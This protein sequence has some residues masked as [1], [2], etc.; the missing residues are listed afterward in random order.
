MAERAPL[1]V[2]NAF[3]NAG[4]L[5]VVEKLAY[6]RARA[7]AEAV[8]AVELFH[9]DE[10]EALRA[11]YPVLR[12]TDVALIPLREVGIELDRKVQRLARRRLRLRMASA[13]DFAAVEVV[14][15]EL[16]ER[17]AELASRVVAAE[18]KGRRRFL[19]RPRRSAG[20]VF[21][22]LHIPDDEEIV[23]WR[24]DVIENPDCNDDDEAVAKKAMRRRGSTLLDAYLEAEVEVAMELRR[25]RR[26]HPIC[27]RD[28]NPSVELDDY[29]SALRSAYV[30][31]AAFMGKEEPTLVQVEE[32]IRTRSVALI[33]DDRCVANALNEYCAAEAELRLAKAHRQQTKLISQLRFTTD[34]AQYKHRLWSR[35]QAR[36]RTLATIFDLPDEEGDF[37]D[38]D[39]A[40]SLTDEGTYVAHARTA[41]AK[42]VKDSYFLFLQRQKTVFTAAGHSSGA[43][44]VSE[45]LKRRL[46]QLTADA[47]RLQRSAQRRSNA[48]L[49]RFPFL[50]TR[51]YMSVLLPELRLDEDDVFVRLAEERE[52]LLKPP[53]ELRDRYPFLPASIDGVPIEELGLETDAE[54]MRLASQREDLLGPLRAKLKGVQDREEAMRTRMSEL[55]AAHIAEENTQRNKYSFVDIQEL[56]V[57]LQRL[58]LEHDVPFMSMYAEYVKV[59]CSQATEGSS[60]L[61]GPKAG[62]RNRLS[63]LL[64]SFEPTSA[65]PVLRPHAKSAAHKK[66]E[67][68]MRDWV[69][70][71]AEEEAVWE[72]ATMME[73]ESLADRFPFLPVEPIFG[74]HLGETG[75]LQDVVFC[76]IAAEVER[77]RKNI[78]PAEEIAA[79]EKA[80]VT[81]VMKL[82]EEKHDESARRRRCFPHLPQ[83]VA[84]VLVSDMELPESIGIYE[85]DAESA[86]LAYHKAAARAKRRRVWGVEEDEAVR[87]RHPFLEMNDMHGVPLRQLSL[88][89]DSIF[90]SYLSKWRKVLS[91]ETIDREKLRIY[92]DLLRE[93]AEERALH[94]VDV[95]TFMVGRLRALQLGDALPLEMPLLDMHS[96]LVRDRDPIVAEHESGSVPAT[97][98]EDSALVTTMSTVYKC[99]ADE[100]QQEVTLLRQR[101]PWSVRDVNPALDHDEE[102]QQL[103]QQ[104]QRLLENS[105]QVDTMESIEKEERKRS[106]ELIED[107]VYVS[108]AAQACAS[109]AQKPLRRLTSDELTCRWKYRLRLEHHRRRVVTFEDI[110][111]E[112]R[113]AGEA[114]A[115]S[116]KRRKPRDRKKRGMSWSKLDMDAVPDNVF[117][118][119][120]EDEYHTS[121]A[122]SVQLSDV[123]GGSEAENPS[124]PAT[125]VPEGGLSGPHRRH[126]SS[127]PRQRLG[128][129]KA[130]RVAVVEASTMRDDD[131]ITPVD[132]D[133]SNLT[134]TAL[135]VS[136]SNTDALQQQQQA[137]TV[138]SGSDVS[139]VSPRPGESLG[140]DRKKKKR[141]LKKRL[142]AHRTS[143]T[144]VSSIP[145]LVS[146]ELVEQDMDEIGTAVSA[147]SERNVGSKSRSSQQR[148]PLPPS[149][150]RRK[151]PLKA[152][153]TKPRLAARGIKS[154]AAAAPAAATTQSP[155]RQR[156]ASAKSS[157]EPHSRSHS[158]STKTTPEPVVT[159]KT[160]K[161][162]TS[163]VSAQA[164]TAAG[165]APEVTV[166][167]L[168]EQQSEQK[169]QM[170][171]TAV[172]SRAAMATG[173]KLELEDQRPCTP[174]ERLSSAASRRRCIARPA[175]RLRS[176]INVS[177]LEEEPAGEIVVAEHEHELDGSV[178]HQGGVARPVS[179]EAKKRTRSASAA[180]TR[181]LVATPA[182]SIPAKH[183]A[184]SLEANGPADESEL[185]KQQAFVNKVLASLKPTLARP[186]ALEEVEAASVPMD[187]VYEHHDLDAYAAATGHSSALLKARQKELEDALKKWIVQRATKPQEPA[188][189]CAESIQHLRQERQ[190]L[191][192][193]RRNPAENPRDVPLRWAWLTPE[194]LDEDAE[195]RQLMSSGASQA[196]ITDH[197]TAWSLRKQTAN[198]ALFSRF[199]FLPALPSG[200]ALTE[201]SFTND[202]DFQR[203]IRGGVYQESV[204]VQH[205]MCDVVEKLARAKAAAAESRR[206]NRYVDR[207]RVTVETTRDP[208]AGAEASKGALAAGGDLTQLVKNAQELME[209][210]EDRQLLDAISAA[211]EKRSSRFLDKRKRLAFITQS[212]Q[213]AERL[214][215]RMMIRMKKEKTADIPLSTEDVETL[216]NFFDGVDLDHFGVLDRTDAT[217][218]IMITIGESKRM[219]RADLEKLLFPDIPRGSPLPTLVDFS[220]FSKFYKAVALQDLVKQD[221]SFDQQNV[222]MR[223]ANA[224]QGSSG[225]NAGAVAGPTAVPSRRPEPPSTNERVSGAAVGRRGRLSV[226]P[227]TTFSQE[228][229]LAAAA[230]SSNRPS[231]ANRNASASSSGPTHGQ[232]ALPLQPRRPFAETTRVNE[233]PMSTNLRLRNAAG[234]GHNRSD[235]PAPA[236]TDQWF[237]NG[238][239]TS[240]HSNTSN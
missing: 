97:S 38:D 236:R 156:L 151:M 198:E 114:L 83:R 188:K 135:P 169:P 155:A 159:T 84:G 167:L 61:K 90:M 71:R 218:F 173:R 207:V 85:N 194:E 49:Q 200:Y 150:Q 179:S 93:R 219:F 101:Y 238:R 15:G 212:K 235:G 86:L 3:S 70:R 102:F 91:K 140:A 40:D 185:A 139:G 14:E 240:G 226:A 31:W 35:R 168:N 28:V 52:K 37:V 141:V 208:G 131:R 98:A 96:E 176:R 20:V 128:S 191:L 149:S 58:H 142:R 144:S 82:A 230:T 118:E 206:P 116:Q 107:K 60:V 111:D 145:D 94:I 132:A 103:E 25:L 217:D 184:Y 162:G 231:T 10:D 125:H 161:R 53:S 69:M 8:K 205:Q 74:V 92:E 180:K 16:Q 88:A 213:D 216:R 23:E 13:V 80:L 18:M 75:A 72:V 239:P 105:H 160:R 7:V 32:D 199:S 26:A 215:K 110:P 221:F 121:L 222:G 138:V 59:R 21:T 87:S 130:E 220:D 134:S 4:R 232:F 5:S 234:D 43:R 9:I 152:V 175:S 117:T 109:A 204:H 81:H 34:V 192:A 126:R 17:V 55:V 201:I 51:Y 46:R 99:V 24:L 183:T 190:R 148:G 64:L 224:I 11:R 182:L 66:L 164:L 178:T 227:S 63:S 54:F 113:Q 233:V 202:P 166:G 45:L 181:N 229:S 170:E 47:A 106:V 100:L 33:G 57:S 123:P 157:S 108:E 22:A 189:Q 193:T 12:H 146:G 137:D 154:M 237:V 68:D 30:D 29:M 27:V 153:P 56:P 119:I 210:P 48:V 214:I 112:V 165:E 127:G 122:G 172:P 39:G 2:G 197:L 50:Q 95:N 19:P 133:D 76:A 195:L 187:Y 62:D 129:A 89:D 36:R 65:T 6:D 124:A 136:A 77:A 211:R 177:E 79:A 67:K 42:A 174:S 44:C 186:I 225:G 120:K 196:R 73:L 1:L 171:V 163:R 228:G 115:R 143:M 147:T 41:H 158:S 209:Q 223:A 203:Y 104:R 78:A